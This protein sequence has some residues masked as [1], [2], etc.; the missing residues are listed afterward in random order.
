MIK[1]KGAVRH[2]EGKV[3]YA[4][5]PMD[6][7]AGAARVME[8]GAK[9]KYTLNNYRK[10]YESLIKPISSL[11]RHATAVQVALLEYEGD[12][13]IEG[14]TE[15]LL[16]K[17]SGMTHLDHTITSALLLIHSVNLHIQAHKEA[18]ALA[19]KGSALPPIDAEGG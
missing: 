17:E 1:P 8:F 3:P 19:G 16:D 15:T 13:R 2:D 5:L 12:G 9:T 6:L 18:T 4:Y 10:G 14:L 11:M 7:L